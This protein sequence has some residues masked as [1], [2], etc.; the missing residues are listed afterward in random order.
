M[1]NINVSTVIF[2]FFFLSFFCIV[3][4]IIGNVISSN[5]IYKCQINKESSQTKMSAGGKT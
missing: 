4:F 2:K 3:D 1:S 5:D